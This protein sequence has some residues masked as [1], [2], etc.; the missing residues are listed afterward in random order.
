[1]INRLLHFLHRCFRI[2]LSPAQETEQIVLNRL[3]LGGWILS[4]VAS[5]AS[6][7][8]I[9]EVLWPAWDS[10]AGI[11]AVALMFG[12]PLMLIGSILLHLIARLMGGRGRWDILV[13]LSGYG[14]VPFIGLTLL[15][16]G[17]VAV[18]VRVLG[19]IRF[20]LVFI[21]LFFLALGVIIFTG[22]AIVRHGLSANYGLNARR[23][24]LA[25]ILGSLIFFAIEG[26]VR[27]P[28]I[29]K[30]PINSSNLAAMPHMPT[31]PI[32][33]AGDKARHLSFEY[34]VNLQYYRKQP[35]HRG[36]IVIYR[37]RH[38]NPRMGRILGLPGEQ[39]GLE[40]GSLMINGTLFPES[41]KTWGNLTVHSKQIGTDEYFIGTDK[42]SE[43]PVSDPIFPDIIDRDQILGPV[44]NSDIALLGLIFG[45]PE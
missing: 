43:E 5:A 44:L 42:R 7:R 40:K 27:I 26:A 45:Q 33:L 34:T 24:W 3:R 35:I 39:A 1:M 15:L 37:D 20:H 16:G 29:T 9:G 28:Y 4:W 18:Y 25:T 6:T 2:M 36:D 23:A 41:W 10:L 32:V 13:A 30:C 12:F 22:L 21:L 38:E 31:P 14:N 11:L 8:W 17:A 19:S